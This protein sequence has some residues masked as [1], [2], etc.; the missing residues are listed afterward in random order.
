MTAAELLGAPL[1]VGLAE[2]AGMLGLTAALA[3]PAGL[4]AALWM[5]E[6]GPPPQVYVVR[7]C[8]RLLGAVP[9]VVWGLV[10]VGLAPALPALAPLTLLSGLALAL[11]AWPRFLLGAEDALRGVPT[12]QREAALALGASRWDVATRCVLPLGARAVGAVGLRVLAR[13]LGEAGPALL[14][15]AGV[16]EA[17]GGAGLAAVVAEGAD[18]ATALVGGVVLALLALG[19]GLGA[20]ALGASAEGVE[21]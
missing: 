11:M 14:I 17:P 13:T 21:A 4:G 1:L 20:V 18:P 6:L 9:P 19:G 10:V 12:A 3:L 16:S 8:A 2:T 15:A 7:W 5:A